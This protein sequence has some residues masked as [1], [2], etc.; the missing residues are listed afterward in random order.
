[1]AVTWLEPT[2]RTWSSWKGLS[3]AASGSADP[4][5]VSPVEAYLDVAS[6]AVK[7]KVWLRSCTVQL[8]SLWVLLATW[9][10]VWDDSVT[11]G[12]QYIGDCIVIMYVDASG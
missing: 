4:E 11:A 1:M 6:L 3:G 7:P 9:A 2:G 10:L 5:A 8:H 12:A